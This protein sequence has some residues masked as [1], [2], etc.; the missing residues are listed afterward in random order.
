MP[1]Q[2]NQLGID[3][4][5]DEWGPAVIQRI[6]KIRTKLGP[7]TVQNAV[8]HKTLTKLETTFLKPGY[9]EK[10]RNLVPREKIVLSHN[11]C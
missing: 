9:Q 10:L 5:I 4:A 7:E 8:I 3:I 6:G 1:M 2:P 11:D